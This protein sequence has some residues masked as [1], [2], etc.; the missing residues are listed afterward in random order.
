MQEGGRGMEVEGSIGKGGGRRMDRKGLDC[1]RDR[2]GES[3]AGKEGRSE[4]GK[5][6]ERERGREGER[7]GGL[8]T[9]RGFRAVEIQPTF[10][11][12]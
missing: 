1:G 2:D 8:M 10:K 6:G 9:R 7:E 5:E 4:G 12:I 3:E 11:T